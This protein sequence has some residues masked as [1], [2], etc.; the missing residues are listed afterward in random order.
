MIPNHGHMRFSLFACFTTAEGR[1]NIW[2]GEY[3]D[4]GDIMFMITH[5]D[6]M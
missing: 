5:A 1:A 3:V 4:N 2:S 6:I